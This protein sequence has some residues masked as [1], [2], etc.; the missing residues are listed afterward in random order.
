MTTWSCHHRVGVTT[1][2]KSTHG[3]SGAWTLLHVRWTSRPTSAPGRALARFAYLLTGGAHDAEDLVQSVLAKVYAK[4][5]RIKDVEAPDAYVRRM[6]VNEYNSWWR[7]Q[8]RRRERPNSDLI[9]V[10]DPSAAADVQRNDELWSIVRSLAPQQR[11][12]VVLR[13]YEDLSEAQTAEILGVSGGTVKS[14]TSRAMRSLRRQL[15]EVSS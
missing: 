8:W 6:M 15:K 3:G 1:G 13:F 4:W 14:H 2:T 7:R 9:R 10:M 11:A 5:D 12:T